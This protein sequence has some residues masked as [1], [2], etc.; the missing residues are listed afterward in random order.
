MDKFLLYQL[1]DFLLDDSFVRWV[2]HDDPEAAAFWMEWLALHPEKQP[3][4]EEAR[5]AALALTFKENEDDGTVQN[6]IWEKINAA[7]R[8]EK[9]KTP[10]TEVAPVDFGKR[11]DTTPDQPKRVSMVRYLWPL[12]VAASIALLLF[13]TFFNNGR[14]SFET[15]AG[16]LETVALPDGSEVVM[17]AN[18]KLNFDKEKWTAAR[19]VELEGEAFFTVQKGKSFVVKTPNGEVEVLG[20]SFNVYDR[21]DELL[22]SCE[23]GKV[24]VRTAGANTI[25]TPGQGVTARGNDHVRLDQPE[26]RGQWRTGQI[27]FKAQPLARVVNQMERQ[28]GVAIRMP[29]SLLQQKVTGAFGIK[30]LDTALEEVFWPLDMR[31]E[32]REEA[33]VVKK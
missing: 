9:T 19:V 18:S 28:F 13:F 20:T 10:V 25:L 30:N 12:G 1:Q 31:F 7:T 6:R 29:D 4:V 5:A 24:A 21:K 15:L 33:I 14:Q 22:V 11:L 16:Q 32:K 3:L 2:K 23:T 27:T 8:E 17:N 26:Q